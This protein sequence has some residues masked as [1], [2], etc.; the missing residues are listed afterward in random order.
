MIQRGD[1]LG[2][3]LK[4]AEGLLVAGNF[5]GKKLQSDE[6]FQ[7]RVFGFVNNA[8]TSAAEIFDDAV[9]GDG[10]A[11][12]GRAVSHA[13]AILDCGPVQ[14]KAA[15]KVQC[16]ISRLRKQIVIF[17]VPCGCAEVVPAVARYMR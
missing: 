3:A 13:S 10:E 17:E 8:H 5:V 6:A 12:Q 2:F 9:M 1:C 16:Y 15:G 7:A 4:A 14:V 11:N